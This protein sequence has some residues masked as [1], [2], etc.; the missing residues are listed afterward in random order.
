[1]NDYSKFYPHADRREA[2]VDYSVHRL[3]HS[4]ARG[5][6][7]NAERIRPLKALVRQMQYLIHRLEMFALNESCLCTLVLLVRVLP[8]VLASNSR[9]GGPA[10]DISIPQGEF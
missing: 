3:V 8:A 10:Y 6:Q 9:L 7:A 4:L 5:A 2:A 1:M